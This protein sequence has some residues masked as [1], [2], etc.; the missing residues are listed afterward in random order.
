[1]I[2]VLLVAAN[3]LVIVVISGTNETSLTLFCQRLISNNELFKYQPT[4]FHCM[5]KGSCVF[6]LIVRL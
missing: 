3:I 6:D 5:W 2:T 1:M 4:V